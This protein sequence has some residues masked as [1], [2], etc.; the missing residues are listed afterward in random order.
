MNTEELHNCWEN[1]GA[2]FILRKLIYTIRTT[3]LK[4][5]VSRKSVIG[6][7]FAIHIWWLNPVLFS[8]L[9]QG[10]LISLH[11]RR[12]QSKAKYL[13]T[14]HYSHKNLLRRCLTGFWTRFV[15]P[16]HSWLEH[17][18]SWFLAEKRSNKFLYLLTYFSFVLSFKL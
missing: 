16:L 4:D 15:H 12:I 18:P 8:W 6:L 14:I 3:Y 2:S 9:K 10:A 17:V 1:G 11:Q 5:L 13:E 7:E